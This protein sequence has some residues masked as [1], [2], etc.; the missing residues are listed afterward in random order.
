M[1]SIFLERKER[2]QRKRKQKIHLMLNIFDLLFLKFL[3]I[4]IIFNYP[5]KE[6]I[7]FNFRECKE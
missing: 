2:D 1:K 7:K 6:E 4:E 3:L 5:L